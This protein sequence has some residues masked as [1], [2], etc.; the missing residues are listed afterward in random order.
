MTERLVLLINPVAG[1][2]AP[3][4]RWPAIPAVLAERG[5]VSVVIPESAAA[6]DRAARDAAGD[7]H[8]LIVAGGDGTVNRV[9]NAVVGVE[10]AIGVLPT[11]SGNDFCRGLGLPLDPVAAAKRLVHAQPRRIDLT[12]VNGRRIATVAGLGLVADASALVRSLGGAGSALRPL[13]RTLGPHAYLLAAGA[14]V[15]GR[16]RITTPL[17]LE[18]RGSGGEWTWNGDAHAVFIANQALLGAG[19]R[20]PVDAVI[21][22]GMCEIAIVPRDARIRLARHLSCLRS[23]RPVPPGALVVHRASAACIELAASMA[24]S[25]DGD[26]L[27]T[28]DR[29]RITVHPRALSVLV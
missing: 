17:H 28:A 11:G 14:Q 21:D 29:F 23:S 2:Q 10:V 25:A 12:E 22:D 18:G 5:P 9:L 20:L 19:L 3:L 24:M 6:L 7:G 15:F 16:R 4:A 13:V 27:M 26:H 8:T 1:R